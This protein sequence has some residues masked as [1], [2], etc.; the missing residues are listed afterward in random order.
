[1]RPQEINSQNAAFAA[2]FRNSVTEK[3]VDNI[4]EIQN[5]NTSANNKIS[6]NNFKTNIT[7]GALLREI[8]VKKQSENL[9]DE[10][11]QNNRNDK[12]NIDTARLDNKK[13]DKINLNQTEI[14]N[15][16]IKN[17][18]TNQLDRKNQI[19]NEYLNRLEKRDEL[20]K[21]V[22]VSESAKVL[23]RVTNQPHNPAV[24]L[25]AN[26]TQHAT[27]LNSSTNNNANTNNEQI[28]FLNMS[29]H[30]AAVREMLG[31]D[32]ANAALR[33]SEISV[34]I[35]SLA[36]QTQHNSARQILNEQQTTFTIFTPDGRI[37]KIEYDKNQNNQNQNNEKENNQ[38]DKEKNKNKKNNIDQLPDKLTTNNNF[39]TDAD[40][41]IL[42]DS[43][44]QKNLAQKNKISEAQYKNDVNNVVEGECEIESGGIDLSQLPELIVT[45]L[46]DPVKFVGQID[47]TNNTAKTKEDD[48]KDNEDDNAENNNGNFGMSRRNRLLLRVAS[49]CRSMVNQYNTF[50]IKLNLDTSGELF[51][52]VKRNK[53]NYTVSFLATNTNIAQ[54]LN[55]GIDSLKQSLAE[56]N[57]N[58]NNVTVNVGQL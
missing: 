44:S 18:Y 53:N 31:Q 34:T 45:I 25:T 5:E 52:K 11:L 20:N 6:I 15:A 30:R 33:P 9:N 58:L 17:D 49:A 38:N 57:V 19:R 8:D 4:N 42:N 37:E 32:V 39:L 54:N 27:T 41:D 23:H 36:A 48:P 50:R 51:I 12:K 28:K 56:D 29:N 16:S 55:K 13:L 21:S 3:N 7:I 24:N 2:A 47:L 40:S 35:M 14:R 43:Y 46:S 22:T 26:Q 10:N 1:M